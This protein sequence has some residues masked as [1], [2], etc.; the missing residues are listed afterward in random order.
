[1]RLG[2]KPDDRLEDAEIIHQ[3]DQR[4]KGYQR[5]QMWD[6]HIAHLLA[7]GGAIDHS[8]FQ[9]VFRQGLQ[10]RVKHDKGKGR[11]V[12]DAID[13]QHHPGQPGRGFK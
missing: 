9:L 3:L 12:P 13:N 4:H 7:P 8:A 1:M 2:I 10:A 6:H 11:C 5:H